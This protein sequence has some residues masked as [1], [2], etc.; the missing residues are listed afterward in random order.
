MSSNSN[1]CRRFLK[2]LHANTRRFCQQ[3]ILRQAWEGEDYQAILRY[4]KTQGGL[5][6]ERPWSRWRPVRSFMPN[7]RIEEAAHAFDKKV[8]SKQQFLGKVNS[9]A[10]PIRQFPST[11]TGYKL[12]P[13]GSSSTRLR[14]S[15][16]PFTKAHCGGTT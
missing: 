16:F 8:T 4:E 15:D 1:L 11:L 12:S 6:G 10:S 7:E 5:G 9:I 13:G 3:L 14:F 2:G